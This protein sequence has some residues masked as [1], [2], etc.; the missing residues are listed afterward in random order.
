MLLQINDTPRRTIP[1]T[2]V[3]PRFTAARRED[4]AVVVM[5]V[6]EE[7]FEGLEHDPDPWEI[8]GYNNE[9]AARIAMEKRASRCP[10]Y[11]F[12]SNGRVVRG[13]FTQ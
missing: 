6:S 11:E 7:D 8:T 4:D 9:R 5:L 2:T 12:E 10:Y 13:F 1:S 3:H